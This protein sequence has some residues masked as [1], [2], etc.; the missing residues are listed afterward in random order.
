MQTCQP[1]PHAGEESV[2]FFTF[3]G[4]FADGVYVRMDREIDAREWH[5]KRVEIHGSAGTAVMEEE[6]VVVWDFAKEI[7]SD[8]AVKMGMAQK[9]STAGGASDVDVFVF[10]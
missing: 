2:F 3:R 8:S 7:R 4:D 6:D 9:N 10:P 1:I 5:V